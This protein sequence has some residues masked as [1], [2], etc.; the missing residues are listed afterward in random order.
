MNPALDD[1]ILSIIEKAY[2][3][4]RI[5]PRAHEPRIGASLLVDDLR[6][7]GGGPELMKSALRR[8]Q[9]NEVRASLRRL[10]RAGKLEASIGLTSAGREERQYNPTSK[11]EVKS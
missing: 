3:S 1:K 2:C 6:Q 5:Y 8:N 9:Y 10:V 7:T 11:Q 4:Y